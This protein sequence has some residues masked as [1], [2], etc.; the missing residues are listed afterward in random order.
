MNTFIP[1]TDHRPITAS[2]V[3]TSPLM[4]AASLHL[5][6]SLPPPDVP[7][8]H[9]YPWRHEKH[10]FRTYADNVEQLVHAEHLDDHDISDDDSFQFCYDALTR[11]FHSAADD[12]FELP[13]TRMQHVHP[14]SSPSLRQLV[15]EIRRINCLIS[16]ERQ[17]RIPLLAARAPWASTYLRAFSFTQHSDAPTCHS[18]LV[19]LTSIW[20]TLNKLRYR[21][22]HKELQR[23]ATQTAK[24]QINSVLLGGSSKKL[25]QTAHDTSGPP[26]AVTPDDDP[27]SFITAPDEVKMHT[28]AYFNALFSRQQRPPMAK[29]WLDTPSVTDIRQTTAANPFHWP[30]TMSLDD[31]CLLLCR[32]KP[33]PAPGPDGWEKWCVKALHD[34]SLRLVLNLL[35]YEISQSHI[36]NIVKPCTLSMLFKKGPRT[37]LSNYRG[38]CC[39]NFLLNTPFAWLNLR[40]MPYL[41]QHRIL[42]EGQVATQ[43]GTQGRD[44][45]SFLSQLECWSNRTCTPLY[46]L[47]HDQQ[48][49][50]DHLEPQGFY[51]A[52]TVYGLPSS[53]VQFDISAQSDVPYRIKTAFGLTEPIVISGVTKQGGPV[54]SLKSTLT[55]SLGNHWLQ[56]TL[57]QHHDG[58]IVSSTQHHVNGPHIPDD[59]LTLRVAMVE[60]TDD[61]AIIATSQNSL[62]RSCLMM[63]RFQVVY[64]W[65]TNWLKSLLFLL[66]VLNAPPL[67]CMPSISPF[68]PDSDLV[69]WHD[70]R[71]VTSHIDFLRVCVNDPQHQYEKIRDI[72]LTFDLP[73]LFLRLPLT[74]LRR[75]FSQCL[76][77]RIRPH[78]A[79]QPISRRHA[80]QLDHLLASCIHHY[81]SFPFRFNS[82]LLTI[83]IRHHGFDFPSIARLN[84]CAA[85]TGLLR[86]L[87]HHNPTFRNMARITLAD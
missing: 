50:F 79:F 31:L 29:P 73:N 11:I 64:S 61:S 37:C 76:L 12:A 21:E 87:N 2:M 28:Q 58:I 17:A 32:G 85:V 83:P 23:R 75:I 77:S 5:P 35:N 9:Y 33:R 68:Q 65:L 67:M 86:D 59:H 47:R 78:L 46:I 38:V 34:S 70:V 71:V 49:G 60:A 18:L 27:D 53:L 25:Y 57:L 6:D 3:L 16:A 13:R 10:R 41:A 44:L 51:D 84:D 20:C 55:T 62:Q 39:N 74:A 80:A 24:R 40:L 30:Q 45:T 82:Q 4:H 43:P 72:I 8:R 15:T 81:F 52:V 48:K 22:E 14:L 54:S 1:A 69:I 66:N 26:L 56:D 36:P 7:P 63:E 42:P 19:F